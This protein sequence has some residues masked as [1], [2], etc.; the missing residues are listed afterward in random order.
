[1]AK[2][3]KPRPAKT[4]QGRGQ[5]SVNAHMI[6][7]RS[8]GT[9]GVVVVDLEDPHH[10]KKTYDDEEILGVYETITEAAL[11]HI[12]GENGFK[13]HPSLTGRV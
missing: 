13:V 3:E 7:Q 5:T 8:D 6:I 1:M 10:E 11:E 4:N 2:S 9:Y 12:F